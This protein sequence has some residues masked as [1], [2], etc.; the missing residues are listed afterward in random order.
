MLWPQRHLPT[1]LDTHAT[2]HSFRMHA[3]LCISRSE[4]H[5]TSH[6]PHNKHMRRLFCYTLS[7]R[8]GATQLQSLYSLCMHAGPHPILHELSLSLSL[9]DTIYL[10]IAS[11]CLL[12]VFNSSLRQHDFFTMIYTHNFHSLIFFFFTPP[13]LLLQYFVALSIKNG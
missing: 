11:C 8:K 1:H 4:M 7:F 12:A 6:S 5:A 10:N 2:T 13:P 3:I 9:S